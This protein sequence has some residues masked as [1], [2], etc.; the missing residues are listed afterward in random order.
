MEVTYKETLEK[1]ITLYKNQKYNEAIEQFDIILTSHPE[2]VN[3]WF[4]GGLSDY[5]LKRYQD[6]DGKF[7]KVLSNKQTEFNEEA[8]WYKAL[9]LIELKQIDK[10]KKLLKEIISSNEFYKAKAEEK[11]KGL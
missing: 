10:A 7:G 3:G 5:H 6:A 11:L 9:T 2:E 8:I 4:Y 1:A